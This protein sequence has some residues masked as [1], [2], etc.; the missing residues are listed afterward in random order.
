MGQ[1]EPVG[2]Q[3]VAGIARQGAGSW[4][5]HTPRSVEWITRKR[6]P[7]PGQMDAN[8]VGASGENLYI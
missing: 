8:L 2:V 1:F 5:W 3:Q 7:G 6:V 4:K